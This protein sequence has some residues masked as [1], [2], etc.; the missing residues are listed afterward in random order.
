MGLSPTGRLRV[1]SGRSGH[2]PLKGGSTQEITRLGRLV[3]NRRLLEPIGMIPPAEAEALYYQPGRV[4]REA[5]TQEK[6]P[7]ETRGGSAQES[8]RYRSGTLSW[9]TSLPTMGHALLSV[10]AGRL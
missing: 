5:G 8:P 10:R 6:S 2:P 3:D 9:G 1:I 7:H 4:E